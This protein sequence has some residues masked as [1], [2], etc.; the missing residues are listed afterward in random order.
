MLFI[1]EKFFVLFRTKSRELPLEVG[2]D[3]TVIPNFLVQLSRFL[4]QRLSVDDFV[5]DLKRGRKLV[6]EADKFV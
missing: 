6:L 5:R 4:L 1:D 3:G 2:E